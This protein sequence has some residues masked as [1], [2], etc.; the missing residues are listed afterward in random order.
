VIF[1]QAAKD[2]KKLYNFQVLG[3]LQLLH[4]KKYLLTYLLLPKLIN[5]C[6]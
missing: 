4:N 2:S 6:K 5:L 1:K 3:H